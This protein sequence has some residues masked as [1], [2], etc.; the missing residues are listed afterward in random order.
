MTQA[1]ANDS[2][3]GLRTGRIGTRDDYAALAAIEAEFG[4]PFELLA[5][6]FEEGGET[7]EEI[8]E[9]LLD[10]VWIT[11]DEAV[12]ICPGIYEAMQKLG[13]R[14]SAVRRRSGG[15]RGAQCAGW[16][17]NRSDVQQVR[18]CMRVLRLFCMPTIRVLDALDRMPTRH[19]LTRPVGQ[20]LRREELPFTISPEIMAAL[21]KRKTSGPRGGRDPW[22]FSGEDAQHI[23]TMA[24]RI[25]L[26]LSEAARVL[27][28]RRRGEL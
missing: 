11:T 28:A 20:W 17:W 7:V 6:R 9:S 4:R 18:R 1:R 16:R 2:R 10:D 24:K 8:R 21:R 14:T 19:E 15:K 3:R 22:L 5:E 25:R 12:R 13:I 23:V 27:V 26:R